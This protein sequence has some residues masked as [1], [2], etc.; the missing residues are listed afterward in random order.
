M[1][2][3]GYCNIFVLVC[4]LEPLGFPCYFLWRGVIYLFLC[5]FPPPVTSQTCR[6]FGLCIYQMLI[7]ILHHTEAQL[8]LG[9]CDIRCVP[10]F[11]CVVI[12]VVPVLI[13]LMIA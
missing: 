10:Y 1:L 5:L 3:V 13:L 7:D 6:R 12:M 8:I 11:F 4:P 9:I 2:D